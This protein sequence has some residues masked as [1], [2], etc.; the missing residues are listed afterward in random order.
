MS[1]NVVLMNWRK[2]LRDIDAVIASYQARAASLRR[3]IREAELAERRN[4][5][6]E[7]GKRER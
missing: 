1:V 5:V 6:Y 4:H 2:E 3:S 7:L